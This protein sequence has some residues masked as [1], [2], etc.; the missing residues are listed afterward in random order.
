MGGPIGELVAQ[1]ILGRIWT[2]SLQRL[3]RRVELSGP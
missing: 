1:P 2:G 3:K